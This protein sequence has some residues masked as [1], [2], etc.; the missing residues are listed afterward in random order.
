M[1]GVEKPKRSTA[2]STKRVLVLDDWPIVR[3]RVVQIV[4]AEPDLTVCGDSDD[5]HQA[6][7]MMASKPVDLVITSFALKNSP[8]FDFIKDLHALHPKVPVL[9]F[10]MYDEMVYAE[11]AIRAG[12]RGF[13]P[14]HE[15]TA[16]LLRAIRRVLEGDIYLSD[17]MTAAKVTRFFLAPSGDGANPMERLS[18]REL[19]VM[20]LIGHGRSTSQIGRELHLDVKT[21]ETY[22]SRIKEKLNLGTGA[23]LVQHARLWL[24][25]STRS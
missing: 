23:E 16:E 10:S 3:E 21:I 22:R 7:K 18:D 20:Q 8:G 13:I 12:A 5:A 1:S 24:E 9:V 17:R 19:Q 15:T 25:Q 11:R 2:A 4:D 6:M 14:K